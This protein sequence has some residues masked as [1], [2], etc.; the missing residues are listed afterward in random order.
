MVSASLFDDGPEIEFPTEIM[1]SQFHP[2]NPEI[3]FAG[4]ICG[5]LHWFD[6]ERASLVSRRS[7]SPFTVG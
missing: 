2:N 1:S 7:S 5:H 3:C 6:W 4:G